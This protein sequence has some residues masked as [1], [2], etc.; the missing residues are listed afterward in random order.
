G[1]GGGG[2]G[3]GEGKWKK[4]WGPGKPWIF[5]IFQAPGEGM[6]FPMGLKVFG[7]GYAQLPYFSSPEPARHGTAKSF[8]NP[9]AERV[10]N[11]T[12]LMR[13]VGFISAIAAIFLGALPHSALAQNDYPNRPV[14]L[15]VPYAAGGVAD[16]AMP[17]LGDKLSQRL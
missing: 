12:D 6:V 1:G 10:A 8:A 13:A 5:I 15:I 9:P 16:V 11:R 4:Q 3:V 17:L 7:E 2:E 14:S